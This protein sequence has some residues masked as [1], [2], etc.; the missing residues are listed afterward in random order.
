MPCSTSQPVCW[1]KSCKTNN[2]VNIFKQ[3]HLLQNIWILQSHWHSHHHHQH[4]QPLTSPIPF[5]DPFRYILFCL[6]FF[7]CL[8]GLMLSLRRMTTTTITTSMMS[9]TYRYPQIP[10]ER[11]VFKLKYRTIKPRR[12]KEQ[13][14]VVFNF[15][16]CA[17]RC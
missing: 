3:T 1:F 11:K 9:Q 4:N 17:K 5:P 12:K 8:L 10:T 14:S 6:V 13:F 7:G 15:C 2:S 16:R